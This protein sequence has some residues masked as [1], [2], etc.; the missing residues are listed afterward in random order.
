MTIDFGDTL[1]KET[2]LNLE[3][4]SGQKLHVTKSY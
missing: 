4:K 1:P 3:L 2:L